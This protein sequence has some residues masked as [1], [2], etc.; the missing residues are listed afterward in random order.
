M[1]APFFVRNYWRLDELQQK[2]AAVLST[3]AP[4]FNRSSYDYSVNWN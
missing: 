2:R 1:A 4:N 3:A